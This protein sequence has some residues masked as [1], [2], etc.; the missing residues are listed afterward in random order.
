MFMLEYAFSIASIFFEATI[1]RFFDVD[2]AKL[3]VIDVIVS[4][5]RFISALIFSSSIF[6]WCLID[7]IDSSILPLSLIL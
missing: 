4:S 5:L 3:F 7:S 2:S 6:S 1:S